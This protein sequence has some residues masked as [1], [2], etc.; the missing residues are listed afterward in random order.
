M[1]AKFLDHNNMELSND[2][3]N[4]NKNGK[5]ATTTTTHHAFLY[6]S[7]HDC[8]M[9]RT[10]FTRP[11]EGVGEHNVKMFFSFFVT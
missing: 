2:D 9:K 3:G 6:I 10:Y 8:N 7:L 1:G 11:L 4:G 5:K